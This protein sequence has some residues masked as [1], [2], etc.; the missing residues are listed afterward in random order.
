MGKVLVKFASQENLSLVP[1]VP[2]L[3]LRRDVSYLLV[4][5]WAVWENQLLL[6]WLSMI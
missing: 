5:V 2:D 4:D 1:P 6:G 3:V